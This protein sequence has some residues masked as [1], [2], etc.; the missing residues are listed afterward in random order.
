[1]AKHN[2]LGKLGEELAFKYLVE[3]GYRI[4][5]RNWF[6]LKD[7]LDIICLVNNV[8]VIVEVKTRSS[9]Y[10]GEPETTVTPAK[11]RSITRISEAYIQMH[12]FKGEVRFDIIGILW[13]YT[14]KTYTLNHIQDAFYATM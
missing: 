12:D 14:S 3:S 11:R 4:L 2:E 1:M 9:A 6:W 8:L 7:E 10:F 13:D 5:H